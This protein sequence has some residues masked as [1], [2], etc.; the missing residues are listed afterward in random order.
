MGRG[1]EEGVE[2]ASN[3]GKK[4]N[5]GL[6]GIIL[7]RRLGTTS[8]PYDHAGKARVLLRQG[9]T[10]KQTAVRHFACGIPNKKRVNK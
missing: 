8:P 5:S 7:L 2:K 6:G 4:K 1:S 9:G 3:R 10:A